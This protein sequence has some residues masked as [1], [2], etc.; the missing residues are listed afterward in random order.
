MK[1][2]L[3]I[4][5][6]D[7]QFG[8]YRGLDVFDRFIYDG[9]QAFE[10]LSDQ[11]RTDFGLSDNQELSGLFVEPGNLSS[12]EKKEELF[13]SA[14][15][16]ALKHAAIDREKTLCIEVII[17]SEGSS[18]ETGLVELQQRYSK[19]YS[20]ESLG[21]ALLLTDQLLTNKTADCIIIAA[22]NMLSQQK[23]EALQGQSVDAINTMAFD[24]EAI[25]Y[26]PVEGASAVVIKAK[27]RALMDGHKVF[28]FIESI[29][30]DQSVIRACSKALDD[31]SI[32]V[33]CVEYIE[34]TA[35]TDDEL[36]ALEFEGLCQL[37]ESA[38]GDMKSAIGTVKAS[39][40][41]STDL[42]PLTGLIKTVQCLN[43]R[44]I[45]AIP[46]WNTPAELARWEQTSLY[47][48][49]DSRAWF[50]N[51]KTLRRVAGVSLVSAV[52]AATFVVLSEDQ[53]TRKR[54][55]RYL[56]EVA[57]HFLPIFGD[58]EQELLT[59]LKNWQTK[60]ET[61]ES[62]SVLL[63]DGLSDVTS[64][65]Q[66]EYAAV[67]LG[68]DRA[69][70]LN[71]INVMASG[72]TSAFEK[73]KEWKTPKG[74]YF[75]PQP[76]G[77]EGEVA[78]VYPGVGAAYIGLGQNLYHMFPE[79]FN[80]LDRM[81]RDA[82]KMNKEHI[83]YPRAR[84]RLSKKERKQRDN[85]LRSSISTISECGI[86]IAYMMTNL[87]KT[88]FKLKPDAAVGYSMGEVTMYTAV[89]AWNDA[90]SLSRR[91][92]EY[93]TFNCNLTGDLLTL[94]EHWGIPVEREDETIP[95]WEM[96]S[97]R[98]DPQAVQLL[99]DKEDRCYLAIINTQDNVVIGGAPESC[100]RVIEALGGRAMSLGIVSAIHSE[101]ARREYERMVNLY[102]VETGKKLDLKLYSSSVYKPVPHHSKALANSIARS[103]TEQLDFPRLINAM[104]EQ[105]VRVFV[106]IG[107]DR[108]CSTW[109]DRIM[110]TESGSLPHICVPMN[111]KGTP[112]H[113]SI[114]RA[115]AKLVS[116][117]VDVDISL[118]Y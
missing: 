105:G 73:N 13:V 81:A 82:S 14:I 112:D 99:C 108:S 111:G 97:L 29:A 27:D 34:V 54:T 56:A 33:D 30:K 31:A 63:K 94:R 64:N 5:G 2:K 106:E 50:E 37:F 11:R 43:N 90:G 79:S 48:P 18:N 38:D 41:E 69:E 78:F 26:K 40:G 4:I 103:F 17:C 23:V 53:N 32:N 95:L 28:S 76:V 45:P 88:S 65:K 87:F 25:T 47:M 66:T 77:R 58:S 71:E 89:D 98:A 3:A 72:I 91:L 19:V 61:D 55:N 12:Q 83:L 35:S 110:K 118:L 51:K 116:H 15:D 75:T 68:E 85:L 92:A 36:K 52:D 42:S 24:S 44:Y 20:V 9:E 93:P 84:H 115:L 10:L 59:A 109:I 7:I 22:V 57:W 70:L 21:E 114:T 60:L 117:R 86:G 96:Y 67:I 107:A 49:T 74:S 8:T 16:G 104:Y 39:V 46:Q 80:A 113:V 102:T 62:L 6:M 101:P 1:E 100:A